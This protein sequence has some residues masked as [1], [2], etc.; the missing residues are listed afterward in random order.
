MSRDLTVG[1]GPRE[2]RRSLSI[3]VPRGARCAI[4]GPNG[5]GKSTFLKT[6]AG[7][8][9]P[10]AGELTVF[11]LPPGACHHRVA[12]LPQQPEIHWNFPMDV[13]RFVSTGR[14][15]HVGW[16]G[17]LGPEDRLCVERALSA[18]F[19]QSLADRS[20]RCLSGGERQRVLIARALAQEADLILLDEPM[21]AV[22]AA[23]RTRLAE[24]LM[25]L[26]SEGKT[27]VMA[28]H[29]LGYLARDFDRTW[30]FADD[31]CAE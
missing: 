14:Y 9:R 1:Y 6:A 19:L 15:V 21:N 27:I 26:A 4:I 13:R 10:M 16:G 29:H 24:A 23:S 17:R 22:D 20:L 28:T 8:L 30:R 12:Y 11:G 3:D 18:L 31:E 7:L 25:V 2:V 5:C